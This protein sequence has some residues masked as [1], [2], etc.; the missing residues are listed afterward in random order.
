MQH[1][2]FFIGFIDEKMLYN[3][4]ESNVVMVIDGYRGKWMQIEKSFK[5]PFVCQIRC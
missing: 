2:F 3:G 1:L 4:T 5:A